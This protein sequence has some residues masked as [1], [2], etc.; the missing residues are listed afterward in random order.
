MRALNKEKQT[1]FAS[2]GPSGGSTVLLY[3]YIETGWRLFRFYLS[4]G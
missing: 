2:S 4:S 3:I 1:K